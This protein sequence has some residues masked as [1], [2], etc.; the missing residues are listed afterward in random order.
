MKNKKSGATGALANSTKLPEL[1][2]LLKYISVQVISL[3]T[4]APSSP[5]I[6]FESQANTS[7]LKSRELRVDRKMIFKAALYTKCLP[8]SQ[9]II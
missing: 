2:L 8:Y 6:L 4:S 7:K 5:H 1:K 9:C 3:K